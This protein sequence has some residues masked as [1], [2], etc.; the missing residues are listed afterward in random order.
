MAHSTGRLS[1]RR[2]CWLTWIHSGGW[3]WDVCSA[4]RWSFYSRRQRRVA[5]WPRT[6][7]SKGLSTERCAKRTTSTEHDASVTTPVETLPRKNLCIAP[8]SPLRSEERRVG[9]ER[10]AQWRLEL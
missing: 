6:D 2:V 10:G 8:F 7:R 9:K 3:R 4:F 5:R 1:S